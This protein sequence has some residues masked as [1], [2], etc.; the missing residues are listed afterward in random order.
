M[1]FSKPMKKILLFLLLS[2]CSLCILAQ[3][4]IS[5]N[6]VIAK[7]G[8][9]KE[10]LYN[11]VKLWVAVNFNCANKVVQ[12]DSKEDGILIIK[13]SLPYEFSSNM[14]DYV[15]NGHIDYT[16]KIQVR[17]ERFKVEF[18][19][20]SHSSSQKQYSAYYSLGIITDAD[21]PNKKD[22]RCLKAWPDMK[23]NIQVYAEQFFAEIENGINDNSKKDDEN[24]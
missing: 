14:T 16:L 11:S 9:L 6:K 24:W 15:M 21:K 2:V 1:L 5:Y 22:K 8:L 17:D 20:F 19:D 3:N 4:Q 12:L 10:D 7:D 23:K 18:L 13:G